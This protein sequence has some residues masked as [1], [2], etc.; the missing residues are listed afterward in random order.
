MRI[1]DLVG[2]DEDW[3]EGAPGVEGLAPNP[4]QILVL[5][6][7]ATDV[8]EDGV[9]G[10]DAQ[11]S[12]GRYP[13]GPLADDHRQF[14][15]VIELLGQLTMGPDARAASDQCVWKFCEQDRIL[16]DRSMAFLD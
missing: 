6:I 5:K 2:A 15:F 14:P 10:D 3:T 12:A 7:T 8:I 9:A 1:R 11:G 4:L 16:G 13:A